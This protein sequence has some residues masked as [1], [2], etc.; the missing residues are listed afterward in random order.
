MPTRGHFILP[1]AAVFKLVAPP[2]R[3]GLQV[4]LLAVLLPAAG[5]HQIMAPPPSDSSLCH[6]YM[7]TLVAKTR[8]GPAVL[9]SATFWCPLLL[10]LLLMPSAGFW[11]LLLLAAAYCR[12]RCCKSKNNNNSNCDRGTKCARVDKAGRGHQIS[13]HCRL[14]LALLV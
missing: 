7:M 5:H 13:V 8:S 2:T 12:R 1:A 4:P 9:P 10:L 11:C 14:S 3:G 6:C